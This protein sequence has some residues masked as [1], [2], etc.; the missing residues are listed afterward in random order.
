MRRLARVAYAV[1][2][3]RRGR[4]LDPA[5]TA[6]AVPYVGF[7]DDTRPTCRRLRWLAARGARVILR[8]NHVRA[9]AAAIEAG[10][11]LGLLPCYLGDLM[12]GVVR[13]I[14]PRDT[15]HRELWLISHPELSRV[16]RIRAAVAWIDRVFAEHARALA[17]G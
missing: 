3:P 13:V 12:P 7:N 14:E 16:P 8:S 4:R 2:G 10:V 11:G 5:A 9:L 17:G 6:T 1:Y 15:V